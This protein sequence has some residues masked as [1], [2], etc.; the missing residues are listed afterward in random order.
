MQHDR[1]LLLNMLTYMRPSG[2]LTEKKFCQTFLEPVF[3]Q[4]DR[5]GNYI[6]FVGDDPTVSFMSHYDTVHKHHGFQHVAVTD[7]F[8]TTMSNC[9]GADDTTGIWLM[10][11]M[12]KAGVEGVYVVHTAEEIGC[13]GSTALVKDNPDWIHRV[14][15]AISFDRMGTDSIITHQG[16]KR[17]CSDTFAYSLASILGLAMKADPTGVYTDSIEY[18]DDIPECTN[19]SVGYYN[20][21]TSAEY[22]DLGFAEKLLDRLIKAD[23]SNL[24]IERDVNDD[25]YAN[26]TGWYRRY[27]FDYD[28]DDFQEVE[29]LQRLLIDRPEQMAQLLFEYGFTIDGIADELDLDFRDTTDYKYAS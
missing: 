9:L 16:G 26:D 2:S 14:D 23:W 11:G 22:Q 29:A 24:V 10:L 15:C 18:S 20:Q 5:H 6:L 3:G 27:Q 13:I 8:A 28:N 1:Q 4:A 25:H 17:T 21:H 12:I 7:G 19:L